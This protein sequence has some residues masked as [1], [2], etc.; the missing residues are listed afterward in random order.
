MIQTRRPL[1]AGLLTTAL[2]ASSA[3]A[4]CGDDDDSGRSGGHMNGMHGAAATTGGSTTPGKP[5]SD[6][7]AVDGAFVRQMIPHHQMAVQM[8]KAVDGNAEHD[9]IRDLAK[10]II[11]TQS[12]EI[13]TLEK[14]AAA[15]DIDT[16]RPGAE[17]TDDAK[18]L[19]LT[20][21]QLGMSG[22]MMGGGDLS[23][24][25]FIDGMIPHHEGAIVMAKA[26]L[27]A[28]EDADLKRLSTAIIAAQEKEVAELTAWRKDWYAGEPVDSSPTMGGE[29]GDMDDMGHMP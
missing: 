4:G 3:I 23:E 12:Q 9:E 28:G 22:H 24:R 8:A 11:T 2:L 18:T 26:Q 14:R 25:A 19:G 7:A 13:A 5:S 16:S 1:L 21:A 10:A 29:H 6:A 27:A 15:L 17:Q 20:V